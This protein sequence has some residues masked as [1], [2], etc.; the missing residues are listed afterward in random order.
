MRLIRRRRRRGSLL[1]FEFFS[2]SLCDVFIVFTHRKRFCGHETK[3]SSDSSILND[4]IGFT[5]WHNER[6]DRTNF[7]ECIL[8]LPKRMRKTDIAVTLAFIQ[9]PISM[10]NASLLV[11]LICRHI[12]MTIPNQWVSQRKRMVKSQKKGSNQNSNWHLMLASWCNQKWNKN[13]FWFVSRKTPHQKAVIRTSNNEQASL[14]GDGESNRKRVWPLI[15]RI[16][17]NLQK[18]KYTHTHALFSCMNKKNKNA[19]KESVN[20]FIYCMHFPCLFLNPLIHQWYL[21]NIIKLHPFFLCWDLLV[22]LPFRIEY[23]NF[24]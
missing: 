2:L 8:C 3:T 1:S 5:G 6:T 17:D 13:N 4:A 10:V 21:S 7:S 14:T 9:I 20:R 15:F 18:V 22:W 19:S 16:N 12:E 23:V 24:F 11:T